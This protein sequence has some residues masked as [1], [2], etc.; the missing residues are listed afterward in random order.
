MEYARKRKRERG[1]RRGRRGIKV[2]E[3]KRKG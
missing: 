2:E 3:E 1:K